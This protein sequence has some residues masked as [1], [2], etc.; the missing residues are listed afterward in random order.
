V[1]GWRLALALVGV[2]GGGWVLGSWRSLIHRDHWQARALVAEVNTDHQLCQVTETAMS[3]FIA[4][5]EHELDAYRA[6][7]D[8]A[9]EAE[10]Y[11]QER[12]P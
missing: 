12:E 4:Y 11:L 3:N 9:D 1:N 6:G 7:T 10:M 8:L 5:Q 2:F